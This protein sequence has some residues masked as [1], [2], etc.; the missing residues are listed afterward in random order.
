MRNGPSD[1]NDVSSEIARPVASVMNKIGT[2]DLEAEVVG[3]RVE[4]VMEQAVDD[5]LILFNPG[6]ETYFTLNRSARE[7]W[8]LADGS[9]TLQ[10]IAAELAQRYEM[11]SDLLIEDVR[12][13]VGSFREAGLL[14]V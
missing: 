6:T 12:T 1:S 9:N 14:A 4:S 8:E 7:V 13:I 11:S 10:D 2:M 5:E 3:P